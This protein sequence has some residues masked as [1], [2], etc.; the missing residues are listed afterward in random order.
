VSRADPPRAVLD[1]DIIYS[2]V[3]HDLMGRIARRL[4]LLDLV[5]IEDL[6]AAIERAGAPVFAGKAYRSLSI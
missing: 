2:R 1:V 5:W 3:L 6:L 4:R